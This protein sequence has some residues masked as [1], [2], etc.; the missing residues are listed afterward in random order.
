MR[1]QKIN[2]VSHLCMVSYAPIIPILMAISGKMAVIFSDSV[3]KN[4]QRF[5]CIVVLFVKKAHKIAQT[6]TASG[7]QFLVSV[8]ECTKKLG[9][10]NNG[11]IGH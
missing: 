5:L 11:T 9:W 6:M 10:A 8:R 4:I 2:L 3:E 7:Q 1:G